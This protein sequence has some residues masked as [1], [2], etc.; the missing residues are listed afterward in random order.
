[1]LRMRT[2]VIGQKNFSD[3]PQERVGRATG[4]RNVFWTGLMQKF[5][6]AKHVFCAASQNLCL[7][8]EQS[9]VFRKITAYKGLKYFER[10]TV[11]CV[12]NN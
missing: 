8:Q 12:Q 6:I 11:L 3:F 9:N 1:M 7:I 5:G 2:Y 4:N 10:P